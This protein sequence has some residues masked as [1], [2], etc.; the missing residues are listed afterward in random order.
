MPDAPADDV[1]EELED[2]TVV[3][4]LEWTRTREQIA[5]VIRTSVAEAILPLQ[6]S[7]AASLASIADMVSALSPSQGHPAIDE[8]GR[9]VPS[10]SGVAAV[11]AADRR[12][13]LASSVV[14]AATIPPPAR[15]RVAQPVAFAPA[16]YDTFDVVLDRAID[17]RR[18][19]RRM[20]IGTSLVLILVFGGLFLA[21]MR[22]YVPG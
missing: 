1:G 3:E 13:D 18:R 14:P 16:V 9:M 10:T 8:R 20:A 15:Q 6:H 22:S 21:L 12:T 4:S 5:L 7:L 2:K 17:G 19:R 11:P